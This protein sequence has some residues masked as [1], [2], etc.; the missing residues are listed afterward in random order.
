MA[1]RRTETSEWLNRRGLLEQANMDRHFPIL[2]QAHRA[3]RVEHLL[4]NKEAAVGGEWP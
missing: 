2:R 3:Y 4:P 1:G